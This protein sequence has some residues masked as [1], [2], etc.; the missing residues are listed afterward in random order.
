MYSTMSTKAIVVEKGMLD[1]EEEGG[2]GG[3]GEEDGRGEVESAKAGR[4]FTALRWLRGVACGL[5]HAGEGLARGGAVLV[6][7]SRSLPLVRVAKR[8]LHRV[9]F[10]LLCVFSSGTANDRPRP[11]PRPSSAPLSAFVP[12]PSCRHI[13]GFPGPGSWPPSLPPI[14]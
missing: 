12:G 1:E 14:L 6:R 5:R 7:R 10:F 13:P 4:A 8:P 2:G 3:G 9:V 11:V